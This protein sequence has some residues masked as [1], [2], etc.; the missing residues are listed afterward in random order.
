MWILDEPPSTTL[1]SLM[2]AILA[3]KLS[4]VYMIEGQSGNEI[5]YAIILCMIRAL[6]ESFAVKLDDQKRQLVKKPTE[7]TVYGRLLAFVVHCVVFIKTLVI[8]FLAFYAVEIIILFFNN[9]HDKWM[10][11]FYAILSVIAFNALYCSFCPLHILYGL[12]K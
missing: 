10:F 6:L 4:S 2:A 7:L 11:I 5:I 12:N 8:V 3:F 9:G 1:S